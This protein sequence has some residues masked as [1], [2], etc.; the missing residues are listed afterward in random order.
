VTLPLSELSEEM[1]GQTLTVGGFIASLRLIPTKK[2]DLMAA[3]ELE[4]MSGST[5]VVVFPRTLQAQRD[6]L[7]EDA[8]ILVRGK[9]DTRDDRPKILAE[10][11]ETLEAVDEDLAPEQ[12]NQEQ[13]QMGYPLDEIEDDVATFGESARVLVDARAAAGADSAGASHASVGERGGLGEWAEATVPSGDIV[14]PAVG[15][16]PDTPTPLVLPGA[17]VIEVALEWSTQS[18]RDVNRLSRLYGL[19][20]QNRGDDAVVVRL[21]QHGREFAA[22][23]MRD[24]ARCTPDLIGE[25]RR[26][27]GDV[28][29]RVRYSAAAA[30]AAAALSLAS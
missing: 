27:M 9:V 3:L 5:E 30:P 29:V 12:P 2:G 16:L 25:I 21:A 10:S 22:L 4:D 20:D 6:V 8:V 26:E 19:L 18:D 1:V 15:A 14:G 23:R 28:V 17:L 24:G 11:V 7:K 13:A